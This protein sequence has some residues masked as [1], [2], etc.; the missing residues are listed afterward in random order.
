MQAHPSPVI[1]AAMREHRLNGGDPGMR[2]ESRP[3]NNCRM[4][5]QGGHD[6]G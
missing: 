6:E 4:P 1:P 5:A 2:G 3:Y